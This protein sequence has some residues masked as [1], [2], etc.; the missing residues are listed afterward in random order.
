MSLTA[1][2]CTAFAIFL[3]AFFGTEMALSVR[4]LSQTFDESAHILAG[5]QY[6]HERDFAANPEHPPLVKL[7]A[8]LPLLLM[9]LK[10][11]A[12]PP[13]NS[14]RGTYVR[15]KQLMEPQATADEPAPLPARLLRAAF[16]REAV[17]VVVVF[18]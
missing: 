12:L 17:F 1:S 13:A 15:A 16:F 3:I 5:Y 4:Q 2:R 18:A 8:T 6:W 10:A 7:V 14:K 11:P 9:P